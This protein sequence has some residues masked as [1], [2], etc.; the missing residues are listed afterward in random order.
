MIARVGG[1]PVFPLSYIAMDGDEAA[2][3]FLRCLEYKGYCM[4]VLRLAL[5]NESRL[6]LGVSL[7]CT[8]G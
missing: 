1:S 7:V 2:V 8:T 6:L 3:C 5:A 4:Q